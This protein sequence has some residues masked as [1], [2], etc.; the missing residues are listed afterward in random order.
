MSLF[1]LSL[2]AT[3][4]IWLILCT[5]C[6]FA[7]D[8]QHQPRTLGNRAVMHVY[9]Y[10]PSTSEITYVDSW[11]FKTAQDCI[12]AIPRALAITIPTASEGDLVTATC[13][14]VHPHPPKEEHKPGSTTL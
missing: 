3:V 2:I 13:A 7:D 11:L 12:D 4:V 10:S 1:R 9:W 14:E 5:V 6:A 8:Q